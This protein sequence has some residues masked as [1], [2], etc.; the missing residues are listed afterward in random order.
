MLGWFVDEKVRYLTLTQT[1]LTSND[2]I[3]GNGRP[4]VFRDDA[5]SYVDGLTGDSMSLR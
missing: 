4:Q 3:A 1:K 5:L 2:D